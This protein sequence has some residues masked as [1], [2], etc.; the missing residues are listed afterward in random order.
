MKI[1]NDKSKMKGEVNKDLKS[2][3]K[4]GMIKKIGWKKPTVIEEEGEQNERGFKKEV[5]EP[6]VKL[7]K[8]FKR[9][10]EK[11]HS[12]KAKSKN[13]PRNLMRKER[14]PIAQIEKE[15][16]GSLEIVPINQLL[17]KKTDT[18]EQI[19]VQS[20]LFVEEYNLFK[21]YK[22]GV[23]KQKDN[24][25]SLKLIRFTNGFQKHTICDCVLLNSSSSLKLQNNSKL[26]RHLY[27]S[28]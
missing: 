28:H 24:S 13:N 23:F 2:T 5:P 12:L 20:N 27:N 21:N 8:R 9:K 17:T 4:Y 14:E 6:K 7:D 3:I 18:I 1:L 10:N 15:K 22:N 25:I 16:P 26:I 19:H 11:R